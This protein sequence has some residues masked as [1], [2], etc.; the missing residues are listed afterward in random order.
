[1]LTV[2][3]LIPFYLIGA[4][5][6]GKLI[7]KLNDVDLAT[8]GSGNVGATNVA[9]VLGKKAG[10]TTLVGDM[11]KGLLSGL[12][13][14]LLSQDAS[15]GALA[16]TCA[17]FGHCISIPPLLKGGKG[18]ATALGVFLYLSP[19]AAIVG[20]IT[21]AITFVCSRVVSLGSVLA[22]VFAPLTILLSGQ[23]EAAQLSACLISIL[24]IFRHKDNLIR[25]SRGDEKQFKSG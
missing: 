18:V 21:F 16:G 3:S 10:I 8:H 6:T 13:G 19:L 2:L 1:M 23:S 11:L 7:A 4:F 20:I 15:F 9:R 22:A 12:L 24:V 14:G 17:V 25:L 5:P